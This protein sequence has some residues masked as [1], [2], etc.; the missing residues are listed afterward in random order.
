M[1]KLPYIKNSTSHAVKVTLLL[2]DGSTPQYNV[3]PN[4]KNKI[5]F[6]K[7][8]LAGAQLQFPTDVNAK[9]ALV[10]KVNKVQCLREK[11]KK[12]KSIVEN[13]NKV[14]IPDDIHVI[15]IKKLIA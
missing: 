8:K 5:E 11:L 1:A 10:R 15:K 4:V 9:V 14:D 7:E 2:N 13:V 12:S 6:N 3:F